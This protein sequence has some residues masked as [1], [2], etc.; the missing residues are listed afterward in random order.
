MFYGHFSAHGEL[1]VPFKKDVNKL[2]AKNNSRIKCS[3]LTKFTPP[4]FSH[5]N[6]SQNKHYKVKVIPIVVNNNKPTYRCHVNNKKAYI[7][8]IYPNMI[9]L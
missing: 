3:N 7:P 2:L 1:N 8:S 4:T 9:L 5:I 6:L